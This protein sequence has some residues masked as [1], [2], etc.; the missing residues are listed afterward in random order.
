MQCQDQMLSEVSFLAPLHQG[1]QQRRE[2]NH[3][4]HER[5]CLRVDYMIKRRG[6]LLQR[7]TVGKDSALHQVR[8]ELAIRQHVHVDV[9]GCAQ[10]A[11]TGEGLQ[12]KIEQV[13]DEEE[14]KWVQIRLAAATHV[15]GGEKSRPGNQQPEAAK[16]PGIEV[17]ELAQRMR[18][19]V[20]E[21]E[22][23]AVRLL[24]AA[25]TAEFA[26][27]G[28]PARRALPGIPW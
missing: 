4:H 19:E 6:E 15:L 26:F 28:T 24:L 11:P 25:G 1:E 13:G 18:E 21:R 27:D 3:Y 7:N 14:L 17:K 10:A 8:G 16:D 12:E 9:K 2:R 5:P 22:V 20:G 23:M